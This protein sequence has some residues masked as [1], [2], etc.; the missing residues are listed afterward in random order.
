VGALLV[1]GV[2]GQSTP[3]TQVPQGA[4]A[5]LAPT[6]DEIEAGASMSLQFERGEGAFPLFVP[7]DEELVY[8]VTLS[9]GW[10]GAPRVGT[11]TLRSQVQPF[12]GDLLLA[13]QAPSGLETGQISAH[14]RGGYALY[15]IDD[16]ITTT[17]L[18][19]RW[20]SILYKNV[21]TGS[22]NRQR[23]VM[24]GWREEG[25]RSRY[26]RD[27]HCR[28]CDQRE[29]FVK[30]TW[31]WQDEHHC[32]KCKRAE[33]RVWRAPSQRDVPESTVDMLGAVYLARGMIAHGLEGGEF[34][35]IETDELWTVKFKRA[36]KNKV[37]VPAGTFETVRIL[38]D[39]E[40]PPGEVAEEDD[41]KFSG[42]FGLHGSISIWMHSA[43]GVPVAIRGVVPIG[44]MEL[45]VSIDLESY[46]GTPRTFQPAR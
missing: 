40:V 4:A 12:Q 25:F 24:L 23:E 13:T 34:P 9:L 46:R 1:L 33:H 5:A 19:Q 44:P 32:K 18:P 16:V 31:A 43:S 11:V 8:R 38:L 45:D 22:S 15:E 17:F 27:A 42:L 7:R 26:R 2:L 37:S 30:P 39:T 21:V 41:K 10:L 20:P 29:H 35:L 14:A 3:V 6:R 28:D 36:E